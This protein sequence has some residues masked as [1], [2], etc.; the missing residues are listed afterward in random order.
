[1][2][3]KNLLV[4][5]ALPVV[6]Q[7]GNVGHEYVFSDPVV[8]NDAVTMRGCHPFH[9]AFAPSIPVKSVRL[10]LPDGERAV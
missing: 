10:L 4:L 8:E 3:T 6:L 2:R 7:A 9:M 1:M 5:L